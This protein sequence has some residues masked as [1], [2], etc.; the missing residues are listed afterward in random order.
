MDARML[1]AIVYGLSAI[2]EFIGLL[3]TVLDIRAAARRLSVFLE[4]PPAVTVTAMGSLDHGASEKFGIE[5]HRDT[6]PN[7][8]FEALRAWASELDDKLNRREDALWEVLRKSYGRVFTN[9]YKTFME[10]WRSV[11]GYLA[12]DRPNWWR[13]YRGPLLLFVGIGLGLVGNL[14]NLYALSSRP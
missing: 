13:L 4:N 3:V 8:Q 12:G 2:L 6:D 14:L 5:I 10:Q 1:D 9:T 7:Q 11:R